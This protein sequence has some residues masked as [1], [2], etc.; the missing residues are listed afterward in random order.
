MFV[1]WKD[2]DIFGTKAYGNAPR[3]TNDRKVDPN[4]VFQA[5]MDAQ[6]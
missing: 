1:L 5:K 3:I 6:Y 2:S 4:A